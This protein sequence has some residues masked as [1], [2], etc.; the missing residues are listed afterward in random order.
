MKGA[1]L[2]VV[3]LLCG[4][5]FMA[6]PRVN[7]H[8]HALLQAVHHGT[9]EVRAHSDEKFTFVANGPMERVA[10]LFGADKERV[11]APH[12]DPQFIYPTPAT[13]QEGMVFA[14]AHNH[15]QS[16]W[17][18][19]ELDLK[20]G[21]IQYAYMIPDALVTVITLR[22]TPQDNRTQVDVEYQRTALSAEADAHV[23]HMAEGDRNSGPDWEKHVNAYLQ[24]SGK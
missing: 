24:T 9:S 21:R 19:T 17:V 5:L 7:A 20:N 12:W 6:I 15:L 3:G 10:P 16:V 8:A 1:A 2:F 23:R 22:L 14:A 11:W 13:D 4:L 18:N